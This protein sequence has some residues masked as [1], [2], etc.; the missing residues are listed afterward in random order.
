MYTVANSYSQDR[1]VRLLRLVAPAPERWIESAQRA[2]V[3]MLARD[4]AAATT[5]AREELELSRLMRALDLDPAFRASFDADPVAAVEA[6]G[7][8]ALA[9]ALEREAAELVALAERIAADAAYRRELDQHPTSTLEASGVPAPVVEPLLRALDMP[10]DVLAKVP[11]VVA[12]QEA[13]DA[14]RSRLLILLV[15]SRA[16]PRRLH[17]IVDG[18]GPRERA[19]GE[20]GR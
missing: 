4:R 2:V 16:L 11:E 5:P 12:H 9:R 1:I 19:T 20:S 7:W 15:G 10:D 6:A 18:S 17:E 8:P 13:A 14:T 3:E